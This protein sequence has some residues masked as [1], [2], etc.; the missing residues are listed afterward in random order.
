MDYPRM[1]SHQWSIDQAAAFAIKNEKKE[2]TPPHS[3]ITMAPIDPELST[4]SK[5]SIINLNLVG[6]TKVFKGDWQPGVP[7][8]LQVSSPN[9]ITENDECM[10]SVTQP[11]TCN[12][13]DSIMPLSFICR[14]RFDWKPCTI[15][16]AARV[17]TLYFMT[18]NQASKVYFNQESDLILNWHLH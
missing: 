3:V 14:K 11:K 13:S 9:G 7:A 1:R 18:F 12:Q 16:C 6:S 10:C 8:Q 17:P 5:I 4:L 15:S 2:H